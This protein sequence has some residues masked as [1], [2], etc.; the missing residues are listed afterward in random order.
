[1]SNW[2]PC[3]GQLQSSLLFRNMTGAEI[4]EV[5]DT[6]HPRRAAF[7]RHTVVLQDGDAAPELGVILSGNLH[8]YHIDANGNNNLMDHLGP[9]ESVGLLNAIGG[10]R[11][12]STAEATTQTEILFLTVDQLLREHV[13]TAPRP[14]RPTG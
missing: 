10:Y 5:L 13:L 14:S 7:P 11:L 9:G 3:L 4:L 2:E 8:L 12:H 1:M 6:M